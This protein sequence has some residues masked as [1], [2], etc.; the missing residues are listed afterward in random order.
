MLERIDDGDAAPGEAVLQVL[1]Q[2]QAAT[3]FCCHLVAIGP[4]EQGS[5]NRFR[6]ALELSGQDPV[7]LT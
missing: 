3:V 5:P 6:I 1:A 7:Q 4:V 2:Q